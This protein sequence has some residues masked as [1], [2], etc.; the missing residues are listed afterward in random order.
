M[1]INII[2]L[3]NYSQIK[4]LITE[5][6]YIYIVYDEDKHCFLKEKEIFLFWTQK[7]LAEEFSKDKVVRFT[8]DT[9]INVI[10]P[11]LL[12]F[13]NKYVGIDWASSNQK[14]YDINLLI[15]ILKDAK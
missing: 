3:Q 9:L 6:V 2:N 5:I 11:T 15:K 14:I 7:E 4:K 1:E 13:N 12:S 8:I 10:L